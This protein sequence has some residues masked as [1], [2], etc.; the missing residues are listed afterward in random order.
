MSKITAK[1][2]IKGFG[3]MVKGLAQ[4]SGKGFE[5]T[6]KIET[7]NVIKGAMKMLPTADNK[8]LLQ[9]DFCRA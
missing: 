3:A 4:M 9:E 8:R 7:G 6:L 2:E 5:K 1:M